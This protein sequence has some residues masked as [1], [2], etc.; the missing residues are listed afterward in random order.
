MWQYAHAKPAPQTNA[1]R[2]EIA[3]DHSCANAASP[4]D[5]DG[6]AGS[7]PL[8]KVDF[9]QAAITERPH[10]SSARWP[11]SLASP[12]DRR[13]AHASPSRRWA[14]QK[15]SEAAPTLELAATGACPFW[16]PCGFQNLRGLPGCDASKSRLRAM[17]CQVHDPRPT[18][19]THKK[20]RPSLGLLAQRACAWTHGPQEIDA[21]VI[22]WSGLKIYSVR[23]RSLLF[24]CVH[25]GKCAMWK[26][27]AKWTPGRAGA[28]GGKGSGGVPRFLSGQ[29]HPQRSEPE[30]SAALFFI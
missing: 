4:H 3:L 28:V 19:P 22:I 6:K 5:G 26:R 27:K 7:I 2:C 17:Q 29:G 15:P 24:R 23:F 11:L 8:S 1:S 12:R 18:R 20:K 13:R 21:P 30:E 14:R 9:R 10:K 25:A 16:H